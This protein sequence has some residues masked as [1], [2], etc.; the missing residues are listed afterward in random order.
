[1]A[2]KNIQ[3]IF[4]T[5]LIAA[6]PI[7]ATVSL[8]IWLVTSLESLLGS[9]LRHVLAEG[10]YVP[11]MGLAVGIVGVFLIGLAMQAWLGRELLKLGEKLLHRMPFVSQVFG[12]V[13][14]IVSYV[15]GSEQPRADAVV[16]VRIGEPPVRMLGLITR[17]ELDFLPEHARDG[18]VAVFL[19]WSYQIG[20][21][22]VFVARSA[23]E[24]VDITPQEA[25]RLSL[26]AGVTKRAVPR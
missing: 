3:K 22:M 13:K 15:S 16:V 5:G 11:G 19:P 1:M 18:Q 12:A 17:D 8:V 20:G 14:E 21:F 6:L 23:L 7:V 24:P 4:F 2:V 25:L 26:T 9:M 10:A